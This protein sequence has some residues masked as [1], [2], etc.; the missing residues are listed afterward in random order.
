HSWGEGNRLGFLGIATPRPLAMREGR[1]FGL[2]GRS[3]LVTE[4]T[5]GEDILARFSAHVDGTMPP[6]SE[7]EALDRLFSALL[8]ERI[9]HGDFKGTN[10]LWQDGYWML[11][12]L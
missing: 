5:A 9:S 10:L 2:R 11:I 6:E 4:Y 3:W 12:D 1:R 7:L 8:R